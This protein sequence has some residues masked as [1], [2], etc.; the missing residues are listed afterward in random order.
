ML[1][2]A[3]G[4]EAQIIAFCVDDRL[5]GPKE[6][7]PILEA[8][9]QAAV[10]MRAFDRRQMIAVR[11]LDLAGT[12]RELF[13]S[14]IKMGIDALQAL[15]VADEEIMVIERRYREH[16]LARLEAQG[17]TGDMHAGPAPLYVPAQKQAGA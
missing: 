16:D 17:A 6:L 15:G 14:A 7:Q 4:D 1:R 5:L 8:F 10:F 11:N 12:T 13:E 9:P 2:R 3:G